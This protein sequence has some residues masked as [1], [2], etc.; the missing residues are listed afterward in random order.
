M[1]K[2]WIRIAGFLLFAIYANVCSAEI[3]NKSFLFVKPG[4]NSKDLIESKPFFQTAFDSNL[5]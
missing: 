1:N 4:L 2:G 3:E 5:P